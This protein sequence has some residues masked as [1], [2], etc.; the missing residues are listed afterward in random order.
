MVGQT[1]MNF[2]HITH[3]ILRLNAWHKTADTLW[4]SFF[5]SLDADGAGRRIL[6]AARF[7]LSGRKAL[8]LL[9]TIDPRD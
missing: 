4:N 7:L 6:W 5:S 2:W 9:A 3:Q 8:P 1:L